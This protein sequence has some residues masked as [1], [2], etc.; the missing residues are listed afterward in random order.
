MARTN[1]SSGSPPSS[2]FRSYIV[3]YPSGSDSFFVDDP[4]VTGSSNSNIQITL[5]SK[6]DF[7]TSAVCSIPASHGFT[8][9]PDNTPDTNVTIFVLI[10]INTQ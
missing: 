8:L 6:D 4:L 10:T 2:S 3:T 1:T 5:G 9:Y 7:M